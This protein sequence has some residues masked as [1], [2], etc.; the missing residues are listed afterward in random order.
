MNATEVLKKIKLFFDTPAV[1]PAPAPPVAPIAAAEPKMYTLKDGT[2][3]SVTQVGET[4]AIGDMVMINGLPAVAGDLVWEDGTVVTVDATGTITAITPVTPATVSPE[5]MAK[6]QADQARKQAAIDFINKFNAIEK[7]EDLAALFDSFATGSSE[8]RIGALETMVKALMECNFGWKIAE[9][10]A[11]NAIN[12]YD[13]VK[14][15]MA[16]QTELNK[17]MFELCELLVK[18]PTAEPVTVDEPLKGRFAKRSQVDD[19]FE[20]I[21]ESIKKNKK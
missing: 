19:K 7:K 10:N 15:E 18:Q 13:T 2:V 3:V 21:A 6:A 17:Q 4:I 16:K 8:E 11:Q 1:P 20:K 14:A 12:A 9:R 5:D